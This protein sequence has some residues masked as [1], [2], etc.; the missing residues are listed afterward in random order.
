M[1]IINFQ[2][3]TTKDWYN[4]L[5]QRY[6]TEF[7]FSESSSN[8]TLPSLPGDIVCHISPTQSEFSC[9]VHVN[10]LK[11]SLKATVNLNTCTYKLT[12]SIE[13]LHH[14]ISLFNYKWG[15]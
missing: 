1:K 11:R 15:K 4:G 6:T 13:N 9:C 5:Q 8:F 10:L 3:D 2:Y 12:V 14:E 7:F